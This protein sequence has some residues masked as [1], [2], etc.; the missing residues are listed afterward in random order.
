MLR[1]AAVVLCLLAMAG[2]ETAA[3][4]P[5]V[6]SVC[7]RAIAQAEAEQAIPRGLLMAIGFGESGR[8]LDGRLTVW[9]WTVNLEGTGHFLPG[10]QPAVTFVGNWLREGKRSV[11][12]GCMQINLRWHP[13]AFTSL[14]EAFDPL[15]NARYAAQFLVALRQEIPTTGFDGWMEAVGRYHSATEVFAARYRSHVT[16]HLI[17]VRAPE[18]L[19]ALTGPGDTFVPLPSLA[20]TEDATYRATDGRGE[21]E[22]MPVIP[23]SFGGIAIVGLPRFGANSSPAVN[24]AWMGTVA[25]LA[26]PDP[27]RARLLLQ[28]EA[29]KSGAG[30][31]TGRDGPAQSFS[32]RLRRDA[33]LAG[34]SPPRG[35]GIGNY[36]R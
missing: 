16:R 13:D 18:T 10:K 32:E 24:P 33:M 15:A 23:A 36:R 12:V 7:T 35:M 31:R 3:A 29:V 17:K 27:T 14:E 1:T 4:G 9:P 21:R 19:A 26:V 8:A 30:H 5:L 20:T 25:P 22:T 11:D 28:P 2:L 6:P 34:D